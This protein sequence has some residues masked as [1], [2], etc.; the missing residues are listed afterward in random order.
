MSDVAIPSTVA[1]AGEFRRGWSVVLACF[2]TATFAWGFGFYGQSVYLAALHQTR[3]WPSSLIA[4]AT[5]VYYLAGGLLLAYVHRAIEILG[6]RLLFVLGA[7]VLGASAIG[8]SRVQAPWQLYVGGIVMAAGWAA[9]TTTAIATTLAY[10]FERKRGLA[11]SLALNGASAGGFII[12]PLLVRIT[13]SMG[14]GQGVLVSV[15][16]GLV[17]LLPVVVAGIGRVPSGDRRAPSPGWSQPQQAG[18]PVVTSQGQALLS[19]HFWSIALPFALAL[20]AQVGFIVHQVAFLLPRLGSD[21]A[22]TAVAATAAAACG[23]RIALAPVIDLM[24][25]RVASAISFALQALGLGLMLAAPD[26]AAAL[27]S[28]S[29]VFGLSVGNVITLPALIVQRE[30]A[31]QCFGLVVGLSSMVG[32]SVMAFGPTLLGLARD[33][34]GSYEAAIGLCMALQLAAAVIVL[35]KPRQKGAAARFS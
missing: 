15:L 12:T 35:V 17:A 13:H 5:T 7:L 28:G 27:Y 31:A 6:P 30:F 20:A 8:L 22:G 34:T 3:G 4:S 26:Q 18:L 2:L 21:G 9:T 32:Y 33:A 16:V 14:L 24:N 1:S 25:Q 23:G 10:W 19:V 11:L 29:V